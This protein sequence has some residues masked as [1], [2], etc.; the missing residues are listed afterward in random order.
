MGGCYGG[1]RAKQMERRIMKSKNNQINFGPSVDASSYSPAT[2]A[3]AKKFKRFLG[4][5]LRP[6]SG[7]VELGSNHIKYSTITVPVSPTNNITG[8]DTEAGVLTNSSEAN[9]EMMKTVLPCSIT[10][11]TRDL[12]NSRRNKENSIVNVDTNHERL[13]SRELPS[14]NSKLSSVRKPSKVTSGWI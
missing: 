2:L 10:L 11:T 13:E 14:G 6:E 3:A 5:H 7:E 1:R 4:K 12:E 9:L 8:L